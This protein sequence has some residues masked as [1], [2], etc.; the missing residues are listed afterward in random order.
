MGH[1]RIK[2]FNVEQKKTLATFHSQ[3]IT[4]RI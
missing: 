1:G 2:A 3:S 4:C